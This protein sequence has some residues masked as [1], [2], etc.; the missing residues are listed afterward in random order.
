MMSGTDAWAW[1]VWPRILSMFISIGQ[2]GP[3]LGSYVDK[4]RLTYPIGYCT[5]SV[6]LFGRAKSRR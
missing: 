4:L 1:C 6:R 2:C 5:E 3:T